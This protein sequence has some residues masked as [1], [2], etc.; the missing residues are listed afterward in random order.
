M[1]PPPGS[2]S[3]PGSVEAPRLS[4][5]SSSPPQPRVPASLSPPHPPPP[6][7]LEEIREGRG[8]ENLLGLLRSR[9][10]RALGD[11]GGIRPSELFSTN[12][13]VDFVNEREMR[14]LTTQATFFVAEEGIVPVKEGVEDYLLRHSFFAEG[15]GP[16]VPRKLELK[17]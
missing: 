15:K 7:L 4:V 14:A 9:C 13:D 16:M 11:Q 6:A 5:R 12:D 2:G 1:R 10:C 17:V 8:E 3:G